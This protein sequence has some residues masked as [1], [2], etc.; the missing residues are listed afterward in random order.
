MKEIQAEGVEGF[1]LYN[2]FNKG[3][4]FRVYNE[5]KSYV[6]YD[7]RAEDIQI[8]IIDRFTALYESDA[9]DGDFKINMLDYNSKT[10]GK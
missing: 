9:E 6:D 5:D 10:L 3:Y 2:P 4:F 1:L 8:K 7:L